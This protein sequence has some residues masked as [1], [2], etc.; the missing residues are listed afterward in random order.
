MIAFTLT[1]I[2]ARLRALGGASLIAAGAR[3]GQN[4]SFSM[5][6]IWSRSF[7]MY[8]SSN[9]PNRSTSELITVEGMAMSSVPSL[10]FCTISLSPP[11][12]LEP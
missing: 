7:T 11:N 5:R 8:G 6:A 3:L 10:S 1:R 12:W 9:R 4:T 2:A